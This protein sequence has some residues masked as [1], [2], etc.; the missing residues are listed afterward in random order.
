M[1]VRTEGREKP[2]EYYDPNEW[3]FIEP[4]FRAT[5]YVP[6]RKKYRNTSLVIWFDGKTG[7]FET[8]NTIY[9]PEAA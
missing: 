3:L 2:V 4:G 9:K 6:A 1:N 8:L 5:V 7:E